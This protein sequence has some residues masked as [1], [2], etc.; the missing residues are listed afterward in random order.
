MSQDT[1]YL[2]GTRGPVIP[3]PAGAAARPPLYRQSMRSQSSA[4]LRSINA[5]RSIGR[6]V[7]SASANQ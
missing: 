6:Y 1:S 3:A 7:P 4:A 5:L 2:H